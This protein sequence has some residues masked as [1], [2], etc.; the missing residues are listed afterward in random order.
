MLFALICLGFV[1]AE[2][3]PFVAHA[4]TMGR[5]WGKCCLGRFEGTSRKHMANIHIHSLQA[6]LK[7]L[8][9]GRLH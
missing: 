4:S 7:D 9:E 1:D 2:K 6:P 3:V 8:F 5:Q